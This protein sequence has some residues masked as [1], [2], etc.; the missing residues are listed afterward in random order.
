MY[1]PM[2]SSRRIAGTVATVLLTCT[3]A[4]GCSELDKG[5]DCVQTAD[6]L[7]VSVAKLEKALSSTEKGDHARAQQAMDDIDAELIELRDDTEDSELD[8]AVG[9]L[10]VTLHPVREAVTKGDSS[11]NLRPATEAATEVVKVCTP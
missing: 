9:E 11:P 7:A 6:S 3:V 4:V 2:A 1:R 10:T 8:E 5:I